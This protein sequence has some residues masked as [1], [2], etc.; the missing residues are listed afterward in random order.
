MFEMNNMNKMQNYDND[1]KLS[2]N[3][4]NNFRV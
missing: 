3:K 4:I 1:I 2:K